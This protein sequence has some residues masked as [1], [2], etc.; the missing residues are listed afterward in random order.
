MVP[1]AKLS[2]VPDSFSAVRDVKQTIRDTP[3]EAFTVPVAPDTLRE[4]LAEAGANEN[5]DSERVSRTF[6]MA[7]I[8]STDPSP[9]VPSAPIPST[10][11][12]PR[13][14]LGP[15]AGLRQRTM[16][17]PGAPLRISSARIIVGTPQATRI[18]V[19]LRAASLA[20]APVTRAAA[21]PLSDAMPMPMPMPSAAWLRVTFTRVALVVAT[22]ALTGGLLARL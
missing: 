10:E 6:V 19:K 14:L 15:R 2:S 20:P 4:L 9:V 11:P 8:P 1:R 21:Q 18:D 7:P 13:M 5:P 16:P 12:A 17:L 3:R 22:A